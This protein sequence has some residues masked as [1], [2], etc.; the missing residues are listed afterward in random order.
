MTST[1]KKYIDIKHSQLNSQPL[2]FLI[3]VVLGSTFLSRWTIPVPSR[4]GH[5]TRS[6]FTGWTER[7]SESPVCKLDLAESL[8]W[9][10]FYNSNTND[11]KLSIKH[12]A[13]SLLLIT[14]NSVLL[15]SRALFSPALEPD[16]SGP[17][18]WLLSTP[19]FLISPATQCLLT[20]QTNFSYAGT[21]VPFVHPGF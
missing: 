19:S 21:P 13:F 12:P 15:P 1:E 14:C 4:H 11:L 7:P 5:S 3:R 8:G 18:S 9:W 10:R 6:P 17:P 2:L 20:R 16:S